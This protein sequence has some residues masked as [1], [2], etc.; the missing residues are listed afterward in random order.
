M[1]FL[2]LSDP[3]FEALVEPVYEALL[4]EDAFSGVADGVVE[5]QAENLSK[6]YYGIVD[7]REIPAMLC[8]VDAAF[9]NNL[10]DIEMTQ[11]YEIYQWAERIYTKWCSN[12]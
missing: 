2:P 6:R 4:E 3:A 7:L 12:P 10:T 9:R 5:Q 11:L 1:T 8:R